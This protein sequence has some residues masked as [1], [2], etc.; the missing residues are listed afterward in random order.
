M[1]L[2]YSPK[3]KEVLVYVSE[4]KRSVVVGVQ[5]FGIGIPEESLHTVFD[6]FFR[7]KTPKGD[8]FPGLGLGLYISAEIIKRHFGKIWIK[9]SVGKGSTFYFSIPINGK[10]KTKTLKEDVRSRK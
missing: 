8:T 7:V 2:K 5:D 10:Q 1:Q 6:R 3:A 9:S 4:D